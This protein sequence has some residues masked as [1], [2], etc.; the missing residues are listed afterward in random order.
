[1]LLTNIEAN[2]KPGL[3]DKIAFILIEGQLFLQ[4]VMQIIKVQTNAGYIYSRSSRLNLW[5]EYER[6]FSL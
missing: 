2:R 5:T 3:L 4:Y 1:M 6:N